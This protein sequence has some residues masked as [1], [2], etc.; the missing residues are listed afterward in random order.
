MCCQLWL[1]TASP[2]YVLPVPTT[3]CQSPPHSASPRYTLPVL[4]TC[5]QSSLCAASPR[6]VL[7]VPTTFC[8]SLPHSASPRYTLPVL[9]TCC[10]SP[11]R[12]ASPCHILPVLATRCQSSLRA[13]S[14]RYVLFKWMTWRTTVEGGKDKPEVKIVVEFPQGLTR[15]G[16]NL[17]LTCMARG[18]PPPQQVNWVKV[19]DDVPSH[20]VITGADLL[21]ENL[22]KS[23]NG[24][25]RCVASNL[26]GES[27]DDY[28]LYVYDALTTTPIPTTATTTMYTTTF[29]PGITQGIPL[30]AAAELQQSCPS[31][32]HQARVLPRPP[33]ACKAVAISH[34]TACLLS[35][36]LMSAADVDKDSASGDPCTWIKGQQAVR[37]IS[38]VF[39]RCRAGWGSGG[40]IGE[41]GAGGTVGKI[42]Q[43]NRKRRRAASALPQKSTPFERC[44]GIARTETGME[45][46]AG[47]AS[48]QGLAR[49]ARS[50]QLRQEYES[51]GWPRGQEQAAWGHNV[52]F[53]YCSPAPSRETT[54][55]SRIPPLYT[56]PGKGRP[57]PAPERRR[58]SN[59]GPRANPLCREARRV[60]KDTPANAP[61]RPSALAEEI[62]EQTRS[63][64][65]CFGR[66]RRDNDHFALSW[67]AAGEAEEIC[68]FNIH[69]SPH[70]DASAVRAFISQRQP[71][72]RGWRAQGLPSEVATLCSLSAWDFFPSSAP[73]HKR[74]RVLSQV[75]QCGIVCTLAPVD[76][77][78]GAG[79]QRAVDHA[80]IGGVVAVVVFAMLCLLIILGRYFAR[81]KGTYFTHEAKG[82]DD[83][84]DADTAII[85][86]EGGHNNS[87]EKKEY[88][89]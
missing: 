18:K 50:L 45:T 35:C 74:R 13:A 37:G 29:L 1:H 87:D 76:S 41:E 16:E 14:P 69:R 65:E 52:L 70:A 21:I 80:V 53:N 85:N 43:W 39:S 44:W 79:A 32:G 27:Y 24:T 78:A 12:S 61:A 54:V 6:Y 15:E 7:P 10:Q 26:V 62:I 75:L 63:R 60:E 20:A 34:C 42:P 4:A 31:P 23:Y 84:A 47:T 28:I 66:M 55:W 71:W 73:F 19:D 68:A 3:F 48:G 77:R 25:Y 88:Y 86:A 40:G 2:C 57:P 30:C 89:I 33:P 46:P 22:N 81:H 5:C 36:L 11:R 59:P 58:G 83:A 64:G 9:A 51:R 56:G 38:E 67:T 8:Q 72:H 17:E 82:A 49:G